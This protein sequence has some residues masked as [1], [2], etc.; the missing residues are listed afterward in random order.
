MTTSNKLPWE[1]LFRLSNALDRLRYYSPREDELDKKLIENE[2]IDLEKIWNFLK[3]NKLTEDLPGRILTEEELRFC[4]D[5]KL[6]IGFD[7][8]DS[9][10]AEFQLAHI[11]YPYDDHKG[12]ICQAT[13]LWFQGE[14]TGNDH[15]DWISCLN[16]L[17]KLKEMK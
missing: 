11:C 6:E 2:I 16:C 9:R 14:F 4:Q 8:D 10:L 15:W 13:T 5:H 12:T 1:T 3:D 17:E 7:V